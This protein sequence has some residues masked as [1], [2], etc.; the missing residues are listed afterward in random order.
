MNLKFAVLFAAI[1]AFGPSFGF[2]GD[3]KSGTELLFDT[4]SL[5][6]VKTGETLRYVHSRNADDN[7]PIRPLADGEMQVLVAEEN[8]E[9]YTEVTLVNGK[10]KR[11]LHRFPA[12]QGNPVFVAFLE[13]SVSSIA[14]ATK[15]SPFYIRNRIK[16]AFGKGGEV[17]EIDLTDS[18]AKQITYHPFKGD[19]NAAKIGRAFEALKMTFVL[20]DDTQGKFVSLTT[21]ATVDGTEYFKE[22][23]RYRDAKPSK[24]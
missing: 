20:S 4:G 24:K 21:E 13:A 1:I 12:T 3:T 18:S 2:A 23:V 22:E 19:R 10:F 15:G 6:G 7:I 8:T 11:K 9:P 16:D 5:D 17:T 14:F